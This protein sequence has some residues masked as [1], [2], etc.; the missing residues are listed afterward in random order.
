[1]R[2]TLARALAA[3]VL[4]AAAPRGAL[5][6]APGEVV[7]FFRAEDVA[8][9]PVSLGD[10]AASRRVVVFFW[11]WRRA[12]STREMAFLDRLLERHE[13]RGLAVVAVEGEGGTRDQVVER[14]EKLRSIGN[15]PRY[16]VVPDPGGHIARQFRV[17]STPQTFLVSPAGRVVFHLEGYRTEDEALLDQRIAEFLGIVEAP[18]AASA[19][20]PVAAPAPA[21]APPAPVAP[22]A[23][24][25]KA[26]ED[27][28][29]RQTLEK[30]RYFGQFHTNRGEPARAEEFYRKYLELDPRDAGIW[31]RLGEAQA[32]Q[33]AYDKARE[34]WEA[35]LRIEPGN[36]EADANIRRLIRGEY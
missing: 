28:L 35:V 33:G 9:N 6:R 2:R 10:L 12:T 24:A 13:R 22:P 26:T 20:V 15:A 25:S 8:G 5:A 4:L 3:A 17:E 18:A 11:D 29:R 21:P 36:A 30:Y 23:A 19:P 31:L 34:A 32:A 14:L 7:P 1:M 16:P 27:D